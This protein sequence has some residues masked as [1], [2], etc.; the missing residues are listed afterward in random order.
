MMRVKGL[1]REQQPFFLSTVNSRMKK[2][3][4]QIFV[5]W[6]KPGAGKGVHSARP[7]AVRVGVWENNGSCGPREIP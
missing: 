2:I 3:C 1:L 4:G 6:R 7:Y 5:E